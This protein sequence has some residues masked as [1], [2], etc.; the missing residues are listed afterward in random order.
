MLRAIAIALLTAAPVLAVSNEATACP[1]NGQPACPCWTKATIVDKIPEEPKCGCGCEQ[2]PDPCPCENPCEKKEET[3]P[4]TI[5][6]SVTPPA[7]PCPC[8]KEEPKCGCE[9][10]EETKPA[11]IKKP[12]EK[13]QEEPC[14]KLHDPEIVEELPCDKAQG[15]D[16]TVVAD[17]AR[18]RPLRSNGGKKVKCSGN[19][20]L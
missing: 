5:V 10:K 19:K 17:T 16:K 7:S 2:K 6:K 9:E 8:K 11:L 1:C 12:C 3:K 20:R 4:A 15:D 14:P 18:F 13:T